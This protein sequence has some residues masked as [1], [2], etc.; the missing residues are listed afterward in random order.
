MAARISVLTEPAAVMKDPGL[1]LGVKWA[2][3]PMRSQRHRHTMKSA[4]G[5]N[6]RGA[7]WAGPYQIGSYLANAVRS[8]DSR[9]PEAPGVYIIS[10][11][12]WQDM[13]DLLAVCCTSPGGVRSLRIGQLFCEMCG[14]TGD[15]PKDEAYKAPRSPCA[16]PSQLSATPDRADGR[17]EPHFDR[18]KEKAGETN[19]A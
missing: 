10:E 18:P 5:L 7:G 16:L 19:G 12:Q 3:T 9:P 2:N 6:G 8:A 14:F 17:E 1:T 4:T 13:P 15:S 11:R